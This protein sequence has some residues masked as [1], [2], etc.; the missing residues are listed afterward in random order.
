MHNVG[1]GCAEILPTSIDFTCRM[2]IF[3]NMK[4]YFAPHTIPNNVFKFSTVSP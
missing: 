1:W 2:F 4:E 3:Q